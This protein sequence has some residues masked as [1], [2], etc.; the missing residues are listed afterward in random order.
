MVHLND[1][2][3]IPIFYKT[4]E[5]YKTLYLLQKIIPKSER[6]TLW[7]RCENTA[8]SILE[9]LI[10]VT[11][12]PKE[13]RFSILKII[14]RKIDMLRVFI[15]LSKDI[16]IID[17]KSYTKLQEQINEIGKMIGGW[18]KSSPST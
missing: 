8:L 10:E 7:Q 6:Y 17:L 11:S 13:T 4:Y 18:I 12:L 3:E 16:K 9:S 1:K 15:R 2:L 5:L 14:S